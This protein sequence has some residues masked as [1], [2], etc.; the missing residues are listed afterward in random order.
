[1][2][3]S[4]VKLRLSSTLLL[5]A[6]VAGSVLATLGC[7]DH[8]RPVGTNR[9]RTAASADG[10]VPSDAQLVVW[11]RGQSS[12]RAPYDGRA[13]IVENRSGKTVFEGPVA[14]GEEIRF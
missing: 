3:A 13:Y 6:L 14:L 2:K 1:M 7:A 9:D 4:L 8:D 10:R 5:A 12:F 11:D